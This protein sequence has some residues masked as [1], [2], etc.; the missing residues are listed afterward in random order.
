[1]KMR[2]AKKRA[3][4][5]RKEIKRHDRLY[6]E[7]DSPVI[8]DREYDELMAELARLEDMYPR[9]KTADSPTR[10]VGGAPTDSFKTARHIVPMLSIENTYSADEIRDFDRRVKKILGAEK[11]DYVVEL[12]VDGASISIVYEK[13]R[14][15]RG[16][17]RGSGREGDDVTRNIMAV[18]GV[19]ERL[20]KAS[21]AVPRLIEARGE[22][23]MPEKEF[24]ALNE[25]KERLG[26]EPFANPRN[27]AAGSLKL[28]DPGTVARRRLNIFFHGCGALE[29][30]D[31]KGQYDLWGYMR[32]FG[33]R[34]N[35]EVE[36]F[37]D[38]EGVIKYCLGW[39]EKKE[40]L[41]YHVDGMVIK[42]DSFRQQRKLGVTSK[43]P[44]WMIAYKF[45]AE[46]KE[47]E[48][49]DIKVQVGRTGTLTPVAVLRPVR[50]AGT[51]VSR[52]TLHNIDEIRRK[53]IRIGDTVLVEKSGEIIPQ[54]IAPVKKKRSG[55]EKKFVMP[56]ACPIC[57]SKVARNEEEV[58]LRCE[59]VSCEAQVKQKIMH[60]ASR[61]AMDIEGLGEAVVEQLVAS[62]LIKDYGDLYYLNLSDI[63]GLERFAQ[64][65]ARNLAEAIE[66]SK[67]NEPSR[68]IF[69][70][71]IRHVGAHAAWILTRKYGSIDNIAKQS[72]EA[73]EANR[74]I[75]PVMAESIHAF[76]RNKG[77]IKVME[78]L[79]KAGLKMSGGQVKS[80]GALAGKTVVFTG[81]LSSISRGEAEGLVRA[82]GG[83]PSSSVSKDTDIVVVG[84]EPGSKYDK[85]RRLGVRIIR[86]A[87]FRKMLKA[88]LIIAL[89]FGLCGCAE[90]GRKFI[91]KKDPKKEKVSFYSPEE[92]RP[93]P[94]P[95]RYQEHFMLWR[96]WHSDMERMGESSHLRDMNSASE[97]LR[98]LTAMRDLLEEERALKLDEQIRHIEKLKNRLKKSKKDITKDPHSR[99]LLERVGRV[100]T[101]N[102][103]YNRMREY[104][105]SGD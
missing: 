82:Q 18:E 75:G 55:A 66:K 100:I 45:P 50:I 35:A 20:K 80:N 94:A 87:E 98:H 51:T 1:M 46:R 52:S 54:V 13:G 83:R 31:I 90:L 19:P 91:R 43:N 37:S 65:S 9:L 44:R 60:F 49:L 61:G 79:M 39:L 95:E 28:L 74:E 93:K 59:N 14:L 12:K 58:A 104:I 89:A 10:R 33:M 15:L 76:F 4:A 36:R 99:R 22:I 57:G 56:S 16:V 71:G 68:L 42:V 77:N 24:L 3:E 78:K 8:S 38:I 48:L 40:K 88:V 2:E 81:A 72:V 23:Y 69:A 73:L 17:T 63:E 34:V 105:K 85:A 41:G 29:G 11:I 26:E 7:K 103:S 62:E 86:E 67:S 102:F 97:A 47:T 96:S 53:D 64:K 84:D 25:E 92:Y 30:I 70:L 32:R 21:G 101:N 5:L 6:Y 27:A